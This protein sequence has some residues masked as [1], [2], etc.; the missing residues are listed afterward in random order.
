MSTL[1]NSIQA[2]TPFSISNGGTGNGT[3]LTNGQLWIG[4][5]GN[6]PSIANLTAGTGITIT[7]GTGTVSIASSAPSATV[8]TNPTVSVTFAANTTYI[9]TNTSGGITTFTLPAS[10]T[11]GN[12]YQ[13][14]GGGTQGWKIAQNA[15][16]QISVGAISTTSGTGGNITSNTAADS[17]IVYCESTN[18]FIG[19]PLSGQV[20]IT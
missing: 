17:M 11:A 7:N 15:S 4:N 19:I 2:P 8:L 13:I 12:F 1:Q 3:A 18:V 16:Q 6:P 10:P 5:T 14:I 9:T 20:S